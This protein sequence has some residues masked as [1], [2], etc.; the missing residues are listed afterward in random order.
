M[1]KEVIHTVLQTRY[2]DNNHETENNFNLDLY[3]VDMLDAVSGF[4]AYI[5]ILK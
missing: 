5:Q 4:G 3:M 2:A 1:H